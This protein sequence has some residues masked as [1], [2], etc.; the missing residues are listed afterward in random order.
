VKSAYTLAQMGAPLSTTIT[1]AL[2]STLPAT[3]F[4][5]LNRGIPKGIAAEQAGSEIDAAYNNLAL[6]TSPAMLDQE[7]PP[8]DPF[9]LPLIDQQIEQAKTKQDQAPKTLA[10]LLT[11]KVQT[12]FTSGEQEAP[13]VFSDPHSPTGDETQ[14]PPAYSDPFSDLGYQDSFNTPG[15]PAGEGTT[16]GENHGQP[17]G[18]GDDGT[19][20]GTPTALC[21]SLYRQKLMS[22]ELYIA[23]V[24]FAGTLHTDILSGYYVWAK[25]VAKA[26]DNSKVLTFILKWPILTWSIHMGKKKN[27][28][29]RFVEFIGFPICRF[30]N[31]I[32]GKE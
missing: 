17:T 22:Q 1:N 4:T 3:V 21:T 19:G 7:P 6:E 10:S 14:E 12:A 26:M 8:P 24:N 18:R 29:G 28:F 13:S 15:G 16:G 32:T 5:M 11:N 9:D 30:V 27:L 31:K 20:G 2:A 23:D 25:H